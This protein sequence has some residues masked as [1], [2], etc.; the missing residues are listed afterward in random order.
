MFHASYL[1]I[2]LNFNCT[3]ALVILD[4]FGLFCCNPGL[5]ARFPYMAYISF[6]FSLSFTEAIFWGSIF[7]LLPGMITHG[8]SVISKIQLQHVSLI[9]L[10][11]WV[12]TTTKVNAHFLYHL[13]DKYSGSQ[14]HLIWEESHG[15]VLSRSYL[16][17]WARFASLIK[18]IS[19]EDWHLFLLGLIFAV[20]FHKCFLWTKALKS[21]DFG[22]D[23]I[24]PY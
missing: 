9:F 17:S 23:A 2:I 24:L 13:S 6:Y 5:M 14:C 15:R 1:E 12:F 20:S 4:I 10:W 19:I 22:L 8:L 18:S 11:H 16:L 21:L 7:T 3:A